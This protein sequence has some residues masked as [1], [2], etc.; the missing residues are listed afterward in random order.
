MAFLSIEHPK[1][2]NQGLLLKID[3]EAPK[4]V[5]GLELMTILGE[6]KGTLRVGYDGTK[7]VVVVQ[8]NEEM[9]VTHIPII[10]QAQDVC[11]QSESLPR[12]HQHHRRCTGPHI[13]SSKRTSGTHLQPDRR[14][15]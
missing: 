5:L 6:H 10:P 9:N 1:L 3:D 13:P 14:R 15:S 2:M 8:H 12:E 7:V 11:M 4:N